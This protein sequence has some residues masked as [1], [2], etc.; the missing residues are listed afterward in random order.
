MVAISKE[1]VA[2][3]KK[4]SKPETKETATKAKTT[5]KGK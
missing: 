1:K 4:D 2:V 3:A 5:R